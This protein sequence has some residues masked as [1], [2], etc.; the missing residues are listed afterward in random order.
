[1]SV[2][3]AI[4]ALVAIAVVAVVISTITEVGADELADGRDKGEESP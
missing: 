3:A 4:A 2:I 1:M